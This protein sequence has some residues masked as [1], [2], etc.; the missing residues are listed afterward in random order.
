MQ[1]I[2]PPR[3][4]VVI[5]DQWPRAHIR[6]ALRETG[7]DAIG[8]ASVPDAL[9]HRAFEPER[10]AVGAI[11]LDAAAVHDHDAA[12]ERLQHRHANAPV[13]LLTSAVVQPP[14]GEW[15]RVL[16]R[17]FTVE[18]VVRAVSALAPLPEDQRRPVDG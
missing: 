9:A 3:V 11:V 5:P 7:Y 1:V 6:A 2:A 14:V 17:P 15:D 12:L 18:D 10:G 16:R 4:L 13:I 8:A